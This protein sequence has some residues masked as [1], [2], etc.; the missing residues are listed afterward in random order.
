M[1]NNQ[2]PDKPWFREDLERTLQ[3]IYAAFRPVPSPT[4]QRQAGFSDAI[5]AVALAVGVNPEELLLPEDIQRIRSE[6]R[7]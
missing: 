4:T 7:R 5:A 2:L 1:S 6:R 3:S